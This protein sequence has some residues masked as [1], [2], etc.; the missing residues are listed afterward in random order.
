MIKG[1]QQMVILDT[2]IIP[3]ERA[4]EI[5]MYTLTAKE[6][7]ALQA[8]LLIVF[9]LFFTIPCNFLRFF[10]FFGTVIAQFF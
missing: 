2:M 10:V 4:F 6:G 7:S 1:N 9:I 5:R 3:S 8:F